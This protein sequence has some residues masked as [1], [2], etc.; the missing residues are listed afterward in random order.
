MTEPEALTLAKYQTGVFLA[1]AGL[2][3][4]RGLVSRGEMAAALRVVMEGESETVLR[5]LYQSLVNALLLSGD[6][7]GAQAN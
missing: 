4:A 5:R 1:M 3:I 6:G 7:E 2:L